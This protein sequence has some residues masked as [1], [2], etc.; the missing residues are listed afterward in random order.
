[1]GRRQGLLHQAELEREGFQLPQGTLGFGLAVDLVLQGSGQ[2]GI[3]G[4]ELKLRMHPI[5]PGKRKELRSGV[6]GRCREALSTGSPV[7]G[8]VGLLAFGSTGSPRLPGRFVSPPSGQMR[9]PSPIT[10]AG[11]PGIEW[12]APGSVLPSRE[13]LSGL[14]SP[15]AIA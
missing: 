3:G 9:R 11:R 4:G 7:H 2:P 1:M 12:L 5:H 14:P 15:G 8:S 13:R 6:D 10:A